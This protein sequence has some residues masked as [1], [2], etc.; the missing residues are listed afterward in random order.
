MNIQRLF[1]LI[2]SD[3]YR[4]C[5]NFS[6][7]SFLKNLIANKGFKISLS[8]RI[9]NYL[10]SK[11]KYICF[12]FQ[13]FHHFLE[14][15]YCLELPI[16]TEIDSGLYIGHAFNIVISSKSK[17]GK[18]VN[19]SHD[20]TIGY[21]ARGPKKGYPV[22][23][24]NVYIASGARIIG[25]VKIGN[26]VAIGANAVV[27]KDLPDNAVAVGVPAK[28]ISYNGSTDYVVRTDYE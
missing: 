19:L 13:L 6:L 26:N 10:Y 17:I 20:V 7:K 16:N 9:C 4:Y 1:F 28:I 14:T 3:L 24:D 8:Y 18:N 5:G 25:N 15:F 27:T 22:I 2:K 23:E 12:P 11:N 21:D